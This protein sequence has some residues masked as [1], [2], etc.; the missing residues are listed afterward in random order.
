MN[1]NGELYFKPYGGDQ[2]RKIS[3]P[4]SSKPINKIFSGFGGTMFV[5]VGDELFERKG[6]NFNNKYGTR[7]QSTGLKN[8]KDV[9]VNNKEMLAVLNNN[10]IVRLEG[11]V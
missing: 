1:G 7:W 9:T 11:S 3:S 10:E 4:P 8:V 6:I 5:L 2:F